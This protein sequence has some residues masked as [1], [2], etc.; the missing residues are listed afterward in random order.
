MDA[1]PNSS[2]FYSIHNFALKIVPV[3]VHKITYFI[4]SRP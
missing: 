3:L 2:L 1:K 4:P